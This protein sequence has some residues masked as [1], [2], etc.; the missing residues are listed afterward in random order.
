MSHLTS[1]GQT[2]LDSASASEAAT[3]AETPVTFHFDLTQEINPLTLEANASQLMDTVFAD[4]EAMLERGVV[5]P[6]PEPP[7]APAPSLSATAAPEVE[8]PRQEPLPKLSPREL[9]P[10]PW[11]LAE[12]PEPTMAVPEAAESLA[13]PAPSPGK[14]EK[15][16]YRLLLTL[17]ATAV[18]GTSFIWLLWQYRTQLPGLMGEAPTAP[19]A[20]PSSPDTAFLNYIGRAIERITRTT[21]AERQQT[22]LAEQPS[23]SPTPSSPTVVERVYVPIYQSPPAASVAPTAP[24]P[25]APVAAAPAAP[26][27]SPAAVPN[28]AAVTS[29][30]LIGVLALGDRSAALFDV[31]GTPQRIEI[32]QQI[33]SS[34]WTLVSINNQEAIVRRNGEVRSIYVGQKF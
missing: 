23:P 10:Q 17:L 16:W 14:P 19:E 21:E 12:A 1:D 34:G 8:L 25:T 3:A 22:A 7:V 26:S 32:G 33:G 27:P 30:T 4:L 20:A 2:A 28:I 9:L 24:A 6:E 15:T 11:E 5:P 18:L 31:D 29:H 13:S